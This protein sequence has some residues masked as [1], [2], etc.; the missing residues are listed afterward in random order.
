MTLSVF[1][2]ERRASSLSKGELRAVTKVDTI[3]MRTG[4]IAFDRS[5][6]ST[7]AMADAI[8]ANLRYE[9]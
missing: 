6:L 3:D 9:I 2:K 4:D 1:L 8:I 5:S 7:K